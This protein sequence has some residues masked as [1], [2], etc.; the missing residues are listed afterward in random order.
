[1]G[2]AARAIWSTD[3]TARVRALIRRS[4]AEI[5]HCHNLFPELS[6]AVS[7]SGE[8]TRDGGGGDDLAQLPVP[9]LARYVHPGRP[10]L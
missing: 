7:S 4:K 9:L 6:P 8:L 10:H 1:M 2:T 5:V 3:A